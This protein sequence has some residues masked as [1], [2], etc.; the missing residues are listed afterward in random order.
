MM[1]KSITRSLIRS[2]IHAYSVEIVNDEP[3]VKP[4]P[5]VTVWG[6][7][8]TAEA[9]KAVREAHGKDIA[10]T[11]AKIESV[12]ETYKI[13]VETFV[14]NATKVEAEEADESEEPEE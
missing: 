6:K 4:L 7:I 12:E 11:V 8:T 2:D 14:K 13:D 1:R 5:V 9:N 3:V 10:A